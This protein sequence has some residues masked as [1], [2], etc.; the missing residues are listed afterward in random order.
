[1]KALALAVLLSLVALAA[2]PPAKAALLD[3]IMQ[4]KGITLLRCQT[5]A[6]Q[7]CRL[8]D[9][10]TTTKTKPGKS[11]VYIDF[12]KRM[13]SHCR[14][15]KCAEER[16]AMDPRS[17]YPQPFMVLPS[18]RTFATEISRP[19]WILIDVERQEA[20]AVSLGDAEHSKRTFYRCERIQR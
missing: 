20:T 3:T 4:K 7:D 14:R 1:M 5:E 8:R 18:V 2:A 11:Q 17:E 12:A 10:C 15:G 6:V 19:Q 13:I 16:I 9:R